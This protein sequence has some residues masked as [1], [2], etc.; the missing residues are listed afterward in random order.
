MKSG[1]F[2]NKDT[3][4]YL[5][6]ATPKSYFTILLNAEL[7][8]LKCKIYLRKIPNKDHLKMFYNNRITSLHLIVISEFYGK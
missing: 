8:P 1:Q 4:I 3:A 2:L 6:L 7:K 5:K